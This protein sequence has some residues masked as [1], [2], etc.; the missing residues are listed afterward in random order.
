MSW[1]H[2]PAVKTGDREWTVRLHEDGRLAITTVQDGW[3][4]PVVVLPQSVVLELGN[5]IRRTEVARVIAQQ[6]KGTTT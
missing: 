6:G 2:T 1:E 3:T 5:A 4:L